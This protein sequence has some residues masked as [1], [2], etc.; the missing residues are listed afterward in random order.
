MRADHPLASRD[1]ITLEDVADYG[2]VLP[3]YLSDASR[4]GIFPPVT[5]SGRA[6]RRE[7][8]EPGYFTNEAYALARSEQLYGLSDGVAHVFEYRKDLTFRPITGLTPLS[9]APMWLRGRED[10]RIRALADAAQTLSPD[11]P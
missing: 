1:E 2:M 9:L 5:P 3:G 8:R 11:S 7:Y 10:D 4:A 6:I